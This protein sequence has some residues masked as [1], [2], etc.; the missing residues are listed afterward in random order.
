[1]AVSS[2]PCS[3]VVVAAVTH[4]KQLLYFRKLFVKISKSLQNLPSVFS[5][6]IKKIKGGNSRPFL[7]MKGKIKNDSGIFTK[8]IS[9]R[10]ASNTF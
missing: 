2:L 5:T 3:A 1:M 4:N 10:Y 8:H 6:P 7:I 9:K